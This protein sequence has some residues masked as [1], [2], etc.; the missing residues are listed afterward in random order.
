MFDKT[1]YPGRFVSLT[2]ATDSSDWQTLCQVEMERCSMTSIWKNAY[3]FINQV[4]RP[5]CGIGIRLC[6]DCTVRVQQGP[7]K[8]VTMGRHIFPIPSLLSSSSLS[9]SMFSTTMCFFSLTVLLN[10]S[11]WQILC[12]VRL[13][14]HSMTN[15]YESTER[16]KKLTK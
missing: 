16:Y 13:Q 11:D 8:R 9:L 15:L 4:R 3:I 14:Y 5:C 7:N 6:L 1:V 10:L 2:D 12:Q